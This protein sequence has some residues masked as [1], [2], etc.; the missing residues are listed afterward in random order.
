MK[1]FEYGRKLLSIELKGLVLV[2]FAFERK[3]TL[4][5]DQISVKSLLGL[6]PFRLLGNKKYAF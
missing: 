5:L 3:S 6:D 2:I 1:C 4:A